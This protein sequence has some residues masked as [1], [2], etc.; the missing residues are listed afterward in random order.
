MNSLPY[1]SLGMWINRCW[2]DTAD[3][4]VVL[5]ND[6]VPSMLMLVTSIEIFEGFYTELGAWT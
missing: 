5:M 6:E 2:L 4:M 1:I 3:R